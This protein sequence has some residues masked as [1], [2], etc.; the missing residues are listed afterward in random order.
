M[1]ETLAKQP[2]IVGVLYFNRDRT[3]GLTDRSRDEELDW[4]VL[5]PKA[6]KEYPAV[7]DFFTDSHMKSDAVRFQKE[8]VKRKKLLRRDIPAK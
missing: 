1:R 6:K 3:R 8:T 2:D 5:S 4:A 7:L